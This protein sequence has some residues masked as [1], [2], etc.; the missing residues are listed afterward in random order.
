MMLSAML[1]YSNKVFTR[2]GLLILGFPAP[3]IEPNKLTVL[4][5]YPVFDNL[6]PTT[7]WRDLIW[8]TVSRDSV[9]GQLAPR[10]GHR[11]RGALQRKAAHLMAAGKQS[12]GKGK[13]LDM[14]P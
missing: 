13:D 3:S 10:Q 2:C 7:E 5:I 6:T 8:L 11:G 12:E 9:Y 14:D 4:A 1:W